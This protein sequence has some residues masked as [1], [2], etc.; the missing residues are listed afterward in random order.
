MGTVLESRLR[1]GP[2]RQE[3]ILQ[4][5]V[6]RENMLR[7][8]IRREN[9]RR[10]KAPQEACRNMLSASLMILRKRHWGYSGSG[11]PI[12]MLDFIP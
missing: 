4:Q 1:S 10:E 6:L 11:R 8:I 3:N 7:E 5:N 12:P 2:C 9:V